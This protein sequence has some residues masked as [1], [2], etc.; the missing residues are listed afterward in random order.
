MC[1][2]VPEGTDEVSVDNVSDA[3]DAKTGKQNPHPDEP[4][5]RSHYGYQRPGHH[6]GVADEQAP[7]VE[8]R[9]VFADVLGDE[10]LGC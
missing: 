1:Q 9:S 4:M 3:G 2:K 5:S 8:R 6:T 7:L 10:F